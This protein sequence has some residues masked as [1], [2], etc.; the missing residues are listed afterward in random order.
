MIIHRTRL[1]LLVG[2][3]LA[4]Q[5]APGS[6]AQHVTHGRMTYHA[7]DRALNHA[8]HRRAHAL[9]ELP[10]A[11]VPSPPAEDPFASLLLG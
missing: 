7:H 1:T 6:A 2:I 3:A 8:P 5:A 10:R 11:I 9:P 4:L